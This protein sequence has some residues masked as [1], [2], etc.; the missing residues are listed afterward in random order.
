MANGMSVGFRNNEVWFCEPY[1][2][3]AW[4]PGYV[5]TT[6][7][8]IVG[9]GIIGQSLIVATT[10]NPYVVTG[11]SPAGMAADKL[12]LA[13]PCTSQGS[14]VASDTSV[15]YH[16]P[17]GLVQ[18]NANGAISVTTDLWVT[19]EKWR[20]LTPPESVRAIVLPTGYYFAFGSVKD[21]DTTYAQDGFLLEISPADA[22]SFA[23]L[24]HPGKNRIGFIPLSAPGAV[25]IK[26]LQIDPWTGIGL[27]V[28]GGNV[29]YYD[30]SNPLPERMS[31]M[32]R[33]KI[34]LLKY[35]HNFSAMKVFMDLDNT[36]ITL[37]DTRM[38]YPTDDVR[39][40]TLDADRYGIIRVYADGN[41]VTVREL[42]ASG[43]LMRILSEFK[44]D[45][46]QFEV[47]ANVPIFSIQIAESAKLLRFI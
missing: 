3:H 11:V 12:D 10:S 7:F 39:W 9:L 40:D 38:E 36:T 45:Q 14:I 35:K 5:I 8:P 6:E 37:N 30:F 28:Q 19:R 2:H 18:I 13:A 21:G 15:A 44:A 34:Y 47:E 22:P 46:W 1:H 26:N 25:D 33:S 27:L 41:L 31:Y 20:A 17:D 4:P 32:W 24:R 43:E 42:R 29:Y 23:V 16:S